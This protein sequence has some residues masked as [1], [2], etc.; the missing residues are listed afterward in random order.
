MASPRVESPPAYLSTQ[1]SNA[2]AP[3]ASGS[4]WS[5]QQV[6]AVNVLTGWSAV[7]SRLGAV[8]SLLQAVRPIRRAA[9]A[10]VTATRV[11]MGS[12]SQIGPNPPDDGG[13]VA[14]PARGGGHPARVGRVAHVADLDHRD[15]DVGHVQRA[16]VAADV[17]AAATADVVRP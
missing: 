17:Q 2:L 7:D 5:P 4:C 13:C 9:A 14:R 10:I 1:A 12:A 11:D 15:G 6:S 16:E 3:N 8:A